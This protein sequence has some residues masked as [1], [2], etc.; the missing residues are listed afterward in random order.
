MN[1]RT[2]IR[3]TAFLLINFFSCISTYAQSGH[4]APGAEQV[5][6]YIIGSP[7]IALSLYT[8]RY[9]STRY[10]DNNGNKVNSVLIG[11]D[12]KDTL[13]ANVDFKNY[14]LSP[15]FTW[16][17]KLK[18]SDIKYSACIQPTLA[19][20]SIDASLKTVHPDGFGA[21]QSEV[22]TGDLFVEPL[23]FGLTKSHWDFAIAY[24]FYAPTGKYNIDSAHLP[25]S[26]T[27]KIVAPDN[28]GLGYWTNQ[29]QGGVAWYPW[30]DQRLAFVSA[31]TYEING[32]QKGFDLTPG[33][34]LSVNWGVSQFLSL[35]KKKSLQLN[36]GIAGNGNWQVSPNKGTDA[37]NTNEYDRV[38]SI[39]AQVGLLY[40]PLG[41]WFSV[42]GFK[43]YNARNLYEGQSY[44]LVLGKSF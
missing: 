33:Q 35:N 37:T 4:F 30:A 26:G 18:G 32:K 24:S 1:K 5:R 10:N 7:G 6:D 2:N 43:Q 20:A 31:V 44:G 36:I 17:T 34:N 9:N 15:E 23:A 40:P 41:L 12:G 3:R 13:D 38:Q 11:P 8:Y 42:H 14:S 19:T 16:T 39:G 27:I 21:Q 22:G 28:I 29:L 25:N